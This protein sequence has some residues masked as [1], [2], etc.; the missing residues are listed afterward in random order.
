MARS[1]VA[2]HSRNHRH[3]V[4]YVIRRSSLAD[5][6]YLDVADRSEFAQFGDQSNSD[7]FAWIDEVKDHFEVDVLLPNCWT[8][9]IVRAVNGFDPVLVITG[10]ETEMGHTIDHREPYWL[11]YRRRSGS[12]RFGGDPDVGYETPLLLMTWGESYH[13]QRR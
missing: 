2:A 1:G 8:T 3:H 11:S 4:A 7:D 13:Y 5:I 9:D 10:H 6:G 12:A